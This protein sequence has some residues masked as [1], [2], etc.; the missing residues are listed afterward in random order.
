MSTPPKNLVPKY[1]FHPKH[2][3]VYFTGHIVVDH[4]PRGHL[5]P[6][7]LAARWSCAHA[8][9]AGAK[10]D[11]PTCTFRTTSTTLKELDI[12]RQF[13]DSEFTRRTTAAIHQAVVSPWLILITRMRGPR[14]LY[15]QLAVRILPLASMKSDRHRVVCQQS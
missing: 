2:R 6:P 13:S 3:A 1:L 5:M 11:N 8:F 10:H 7:S 14:L 4:L 12:L 15:A 9:M